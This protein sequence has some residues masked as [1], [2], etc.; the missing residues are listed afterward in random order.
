MSTKEKHQNKDTEKERLEKSNDN[1]KSS[2]SDTCPT[3][4]GMG[5]VSYNLPA[6]CP[7][8]GDGCQF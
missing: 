3:C 7:T 1:E 5:I 8:C 2:D 6:N 4:G